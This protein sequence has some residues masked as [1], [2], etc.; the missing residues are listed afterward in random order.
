MRAFDAAMKRVESLRAEFEKVNADAA[1]L[2]IQ[3]EQK[4][5]DLEAASA[6][7]R[8]TGEAKPGNDRHI[9]ALAR[10]KELERERSEREKLR[11][12]LAKVETALVNIKADQKRLLDDLENVL[13]AHKTIEELRLRV[14]EQKRFEERLGGIRDSVA[15]AQAAANQTAALEQRLSQLRE[16]FTASQAEV[17]TAEA[18][19]GL[20]AEF[21]E[22][23]KRDAEMIQQ[24]AQL[25]A[26][27]ERDQKFQAEIKDGFCPILS[28]KCLNLNDGETLESFVTSQFSELRDQIAGVESEHKTICVNL[29]QAR[30]AEKILG[31]LPTLRA[32]LA[33]IEDEGKRLRAEHETLKK[34]AEVL[35]T[36]ETEFLRDEAALAVLEDPR[37]RTRLLEKETAREPELR[38]AI[39]EVERNLE[40]LESDRRI[41]VEQL[42]S[43]KDLDTQ[44]AECSTER[45]ATLEAHRT[46]LANE[47]LAATFAERTKEFEAATAEHSRL[48]NAAKAAENAFTEASSGY[49][50]ER[51]MAE[52]ISFLTPKNGMPSLARR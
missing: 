8:K 5:R 46:F 41:L 10:L 43:Y 13:K 36:L 27:L 39:T 28:Q 1:R 35:A 23:Q 32:R 4:E 34:E 20:A 42:E 31:T 38:A 17:R 7:A 26:S 3:A 30:E 24:L 52:Q 15:A 51:H 16:R 29:I 33:D 50:R 40:R 44:W 22:L 37:S 45:D 47:S 12:N 25:R 48:Q 49:D 14:E 11:D 6:A 21:P 19:T 2:E 9:A 18:K